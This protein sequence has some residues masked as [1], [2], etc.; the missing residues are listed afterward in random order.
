MESL[1]VKYRP[2]TFDEIVG[3]SAISD[4]LKRQ[5]ETGHIKN[6]YLFA[7]SS[8]CVD[9]HTE[10]FNGKQWK[11]IRDYTEEDMVLQYASDGTASLVKPLAF[12][13]RPCHYMTHVKNDYGIDMCISEDH[14]IIFQIGE[15]KAT[16]RGKMFRTYKRWKK[17]DE[18]GRIADV[19]LRSTFKYAGKGL[20]I[21][22][23]KLISIVRSWCE[24]DSSTPIMEYAI[25][26]LYKCSEL[27]LTTICDTILDV[28]HNSCS[29]GFTHINREIAD[30]IQFVFTTQGYRTTLHM[31]KTNGEIRYTIQLSDEI[32][33][34]MKQTG[35][36]HLMHSIEPID[37][38]KYC[39]TVPT[40]MWVMR[41]NGHILITGN[42]GK[43]TSARAFASAINNGQG[44]PTEID[45]ASNSGV[46]NVR[47]VIKQATQRAI[48]CE[49]NVIIVD[50]CHSLSAQAWQAFL[51]CIEEP[52]KYTVFIF[53]TTEKHKVPD[54]IKNRCQVFNF[55]KISSSIIADRLKYIC[56]SEQVTNYTDAC[57][58]I[59]RICKNQMR[60]AIAMLEKCLD[61]RATSDLS[62]DNVVR[63]YGDISYAEQFTL[64]NAIIDGNISTILNTVDN[65]YT[66]GINMKHFAD[67]FTS[68]T[69]NLY[70]YS[71]FKNIK[72]TILPPSEEENARYAVG[73]DNIGNIM[74]KI[75]SSMLDLKQSIKDDEDIPTTIKCYLIK[76]SNELC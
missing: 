71:V 37:G 19:R 12:I 72:A 25:E 59:S 45:A 73:L 51:K 34:K 66:N 62:V 70:T 22:D 7:G 42:C 10:F 63:A 24:A 32:Y 44:K 5:I 55:N 54:T 48:D 50:E 65:I 17:E 27:Q 38:M 29:M 58:Y 61:F 4:I 33:P 60:D 14:T 31:C 41:R 69:L 75:L 13:E 6:S 40:H 36:S 20:K 35:M 9:G 74:N 52:P 39:F 18:E 46:D 43:T 67:M 56:H 28:M 30:F 76:I 47:D 53:C 2:R 26:K 8:G 3:Q 16:L 21:S 23:D 49:Y 1:A 57:D 15:G 11:K 64:F 68:F